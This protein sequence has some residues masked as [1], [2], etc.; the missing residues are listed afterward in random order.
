MIPAVA[1]IGCSSDN[2]SPDPDAGQ[3]DAGASGAGGQGGNAGAGGHAGTGGGAGTGGDA[4]AGGSAGSG[5]SQGPTQCSADEKKCIAGIVKQCQNDAW[6]TVEDCVTEGKLCDM[7]KGGCVDKCT[8]DTDCANSSEVDGEFCRQ[9]GRCAPK[10]FETVWE[11][12]DSDR[13]LVL[14]YYDDGSGKAKCD[15]K[16][17]WG[18]EGAD[19]DFSK[20]TDVKKCSDVKNITHKYAT[21]GTYH[22]KIKGTYNGWGTD[23]IIPTEICDDDCGGKMLRRLVEVVSFGPV[24]LTNGAFACTDGVKLPAEQVPDASLWN[25]GG[26]LFFCANGVSESITR[27][28]TSNIT[29]MLSMFYGAAAF[30]HPLNGWDTSKVTKMSSVFAGTAAFNQPLNTW[31]TSNVT[32]MRVTFYK[33]TAFNQPLN[34]W[35]TSNVTNMYFMFM[36][37]AA[38]NQPLNTWITSNVTNMNSMFKEA[39]AFDQNLAPWDVTKV[40]NMTSIFSESGITKTN[41]CAVK[42]LDVWKD[43][44]LGVS[45]ACP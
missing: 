43:A 2:D 8:K 23:V 39:S 32:D 27:W 38:F 3:Q 4:G 20:G 5:G 19:N 29:N 11:V 31:N 30:N 15:F 40:T 1:M 17:L 26:E 12:P 33:A 24:G 6:K 37:A 41:Y 25:N 22:V 10:I 21:A 16:V 35:D 45:F 14:P 18:D 34:T 13:T 44:D 28:D 42:S 36:G 7:S 9:D